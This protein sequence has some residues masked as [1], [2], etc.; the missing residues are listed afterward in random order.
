MTVAEKGKGVMG[1]GETAQR[2][3]EGPA[4]AH[5]SGDS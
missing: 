5:V 2:L 1:A 4:L 3:G